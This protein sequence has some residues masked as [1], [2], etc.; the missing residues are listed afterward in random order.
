MIQKY[1]ISFLLVFQFELLSHTITNEN[2]FI[3][4]D[5]SEK[6]ESIRRVKEQN[7]HDL[8][9]SVSKLLREDS[10][11]IET[12][13]EILNLYESYGSELSQ[14]HPSFIDDYEWIVKNLNDETIVIQI[15]H[16]FKI[17]KDKSFFYPVTSLLTHRNSNVRLASYQYLETFKDDRALPYLM[18]LGNSSKAIERFYYL[19]ALNYIIDERA[20]IHISKLLTDPSPAIRIEA[21]NAIDKLNLKEKQ[22]HVLTMARKDQNYEVRKIATIYTKNKKLKY[23]Q[24]IFKDGLDDDNSEVKKEVLLAISSFQDP[25]YAKSVS[26]YL[27]K[28]SDP[29]LRSLGLDAL[30]S[31]NNHGGGGGL[32]RILLNDNNIENRKK[33]A[34]LTSK[35]NAKNLIPTLL[36]SVEVD[37]SI[38]VKIEITKSLGLLK[39]KSAIPIFINSIASQKEDN[40]LKLEMLMALEKINE[41]KIIPILYDIVENDN[42]ELK[43]QMKSIFRDMLYKVH[44]MEKRNMNAQFI[45]F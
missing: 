5:P 34:Y 23:R 38:A 14:V 15:I 9:P 39:E 17:R 29:Y 8:L 31:M 13:L 21:I 7:Q 36:K 33:A 4:L 24:E 2:F 18:E 40:S 41:P 43:D 26:N 27:E 12:I 19:E 44:K 32:A 45:S 42:T 20:S 37:P 30:N 10:H 35:L 3:N 1:L 25:N 22:N 28:E 11:N 6:A 16:F